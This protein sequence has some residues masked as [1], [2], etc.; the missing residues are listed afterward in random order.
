MSYKCSWPFFWSWFERFDVVVS[1]I[2]KKLQILFN[3]LSHGCICQLT[4]NYFFPIY[5]WQ[6]HISIVPIMSWSHGVVGIPLNKITIFK[7]SDQVLTNAFHH[8]YWLFFSV[9]NLYSINIVSHH[10]H[11]T[12]NFMLI[13][14][15]RTTCFGWLSK[16]DYWVI[17]WLTIPSLYMSRST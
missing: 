1:S 4:W 17:N 9:N 13:H 10:W 15:L 7:S 8:V 6:P 16:H 11:L 3:L 14:D 12:F 2:A 5:V